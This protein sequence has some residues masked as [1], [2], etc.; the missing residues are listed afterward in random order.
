MAGV[1]A[2]GLGSGLDVNGII[3]QLMALEQQPMK[4]LATKEAGFQAKLSSFGMLKG[5]LASLQT[6]AKTLST[7]GTFTGMSASVSDT[8]VLTASAGSTAAA[9]S[10]SLSVTQLAKFHAVRSNTNYAATTDTFTTGTLAISIGGGTAKNITIDSSNNTLAGIRQAINDADAGVTAAIINDGSTNR[11]VLSSKTSGSAGAIAVAVTDSGSGGTHALGDLKSTGAGTTL[12]ATQ[13]ADDAKLTIN[14][15]E[16]TRSSNTITDAIEG[17]TLSL[18]KGTLASPGTT[19]LTVTKN[20][21]ATAAAIGA[22]VK[23]YNDAVTQLKNSSAYDAANKRASTLTGDSTVRSIQS[24]LG[25]LVQSSLT[26]ISGGIARLSDIGITVQANG[27][28][29][30]DNTKLN[31]ALADRNMDVGALFTQTTTGNTGIAVRFTAALEA[32]VGTGG[33]IGSRT[34]GISASIKDLGKRAEALNLRLAA[35]EKRYRAQF[36]SLDSLVSGMN[37]TSQFLTQQ[38]ANLPGASSSR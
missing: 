38:L 9:G 21:G 12:V 25:D 20:T 29:A 1:S 11:L 26:G 6:A 18:T 36:T 23:A 34:D 28:L 37:K 17:V 2:S 33:L 10:Y 27:T 7:T 14:G 16:I 24:Q 15:I 19:S 22:F 31:A 3:K 5:A 32:M 8:S 13:T 4:A 30:V 35:I